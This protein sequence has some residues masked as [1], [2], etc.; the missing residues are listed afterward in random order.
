MEGYKVPESRSIYVETL[1]HICFDI[2]V[3]MNHIVRS[4]KITSDR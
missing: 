1:Q 4:L 3:E 2:Y